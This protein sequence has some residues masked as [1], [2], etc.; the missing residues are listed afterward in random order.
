LGNATVLRERNSWWGSKNRPNIASAHDKRRE[1]GM[2]TFKPSKIARLFCLCGVGCAV[3]R[4]L[5]TGKAGRHF[6]A[7]LGELGTPLP[8]AGLA[9]AGDDTRSQTREAVKPFE[10][11]FLKVTTSI[12]RS[13][14]SDRLKR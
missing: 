13:L 8:G 11:P 4:H 14:S 3:A 10:A 5:S 1:K 7:P 9:V 2:G 12:N 6:G